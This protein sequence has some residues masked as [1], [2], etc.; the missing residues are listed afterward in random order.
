[1][2]DKIDFKINGKHYDL[3]NV[4]DK[5]LDMYENVTDKNIEEINDN[6][7]KQKK[8]SKLS[9]TFLVVAVGSCAIGLAGVAPI[10]SGI[11][12]IASSVAH[13][14]CSAKNPL[15]NKELKGKLK[16]AEKIKFLLASEMKKRK[17][18]PEFGQAEAKEDFH[19]IDVNVTIE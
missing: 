4:P 1:M 3:N 5:A 10:A 2:A 19:E 14:V 13:V 17:I 11:V 8:I 16:T 6:I 9:K 7:K 18:F 15:N 12:S